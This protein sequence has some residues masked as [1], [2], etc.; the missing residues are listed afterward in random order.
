M[1]LDGLY[2]V[3]QRHTKEEFEDLALEYGLHK[4]ITYWD[5][6]ISTYLPLDKIGQALGIDLN[7]IPKSEY[8]LIRRLVQVQADIKEDDQY[9]DDISQGIKTMA[10]VYKNKVKYSKIKERR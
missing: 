4:K 7:I 9:A 1:G 10:I 5:G 3:I 8:F 2:S 6:E